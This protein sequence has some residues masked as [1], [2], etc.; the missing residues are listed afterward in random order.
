LWL[1]QCKKFE[2]FFEVQNPRNSISKEPGITKCLTAVLCTKFPEIPTEIIRYYSRVRTFIRISSLNRTIESEKFK[3][4]EACYRFRNN[5]NV[6]PPPEEN[7]TD[8]EVEECA[9]AEELLELLEV[10]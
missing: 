3:N 4:Q 1:N 7:P 8:F 9:V 6:Q 5:C 10:E 2:E